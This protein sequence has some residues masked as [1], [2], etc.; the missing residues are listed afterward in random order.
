M[1]Q[2]IMNSSLMMEGMLPWGKGWDGG[3]A[4]PREGIRHPVYLLFNL[5]TS[6][7]VEQQLQAEIL[8]LVGYLDVD[9]RG[10]FMLDARLV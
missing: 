3:D 9:L 5:D 1:R 6:L 4:R 7:L 2:N 8:H 10:L